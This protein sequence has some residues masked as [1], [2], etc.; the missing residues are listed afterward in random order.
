MAACATA[1]QP[2]SE[3]RPNAI[4][5]PETR[6]DQTAPP[7]DVPVEAVKMAETGAFAQ[8]IARHHRSCLTK[9]YSILR[10]RGDA[11]DEVQTARVQACM[12]LGSYEGHGSRS[13]PLAGT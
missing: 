7:D 10:N 8:L 2:I 11:E 6:V 13:R 12:H 4:N 3:S 5:N 9:A 1:L